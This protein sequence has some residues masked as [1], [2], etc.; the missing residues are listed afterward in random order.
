[1]SKTFKTIFV[2]S[3]FFLT[4]TVFMA[5]KYDHN[6]AYRGGYNDGKKGSIADDLAQNFKDFVPGAK[7]S[8][9]KSYDKGYRDGATDRYDPDNTHYSGGSNSDK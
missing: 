1:M 7:N 4:N 9:E 3:K 8:T 6:E 5:N 2:L